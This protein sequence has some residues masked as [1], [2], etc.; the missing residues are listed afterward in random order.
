MSPPR[1][2]LHSLRSAITNR[3]VSPDA[4]QRF[5]RSLAAA[6]AVTSASAFAMLVRWIPWRQLA[7]AATRTCFALGLKRRPDSRFDDY[8][9]A[10]HQ[11]MHTEE[12]GAEGDQEVL[13]CQRR[14]GAQ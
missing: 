11:I 9:H 10:F 12:R 8:P 5:P 2:L 3:P 6:A 7:A 14:S 13:A 1:R 4:E